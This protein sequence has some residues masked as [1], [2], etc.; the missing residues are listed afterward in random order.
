MSEILSEPV[1]RFSGYR[2]RVF[3][4]RETAG[5]YCDYKKMRKA[6]EA[7]LALQSR[8]YCRV[9]GSIC[10]VVSRRFFFLYSGA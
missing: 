9:S 10:G 1:V 3:Q 7:M 5:G 2:W 8:P 4:V 6:G